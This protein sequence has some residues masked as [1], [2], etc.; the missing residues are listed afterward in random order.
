MN[1]LFKIKDNVTYNS[2]IVGTRT[3]YFTTDPWSTT[4]DVILS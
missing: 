3:C 1:L 4:A 2:I